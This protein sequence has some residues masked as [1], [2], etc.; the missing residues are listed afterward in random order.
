MGGFALY[1]GNKYVS[2]LRFIPSKEAKERIMENFET[3][4]SRAGITSLSND[5]GHDDNTD[6]IYLSRDKDRTLPSSHLF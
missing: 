5:S 1:E 2:V 4:E 3:E 6:T